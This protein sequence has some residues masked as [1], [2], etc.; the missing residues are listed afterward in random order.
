MKQLVPGHSPS[1]I[2]RYPSWLHR[3]DNELIYG[4]QNSELFK[5]NFMPKGGIRM[6]EATLKEKVMS[7]SSCSRIFY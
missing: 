3:Q 4:I 6:A 2:A 7:G 5:L 1:H